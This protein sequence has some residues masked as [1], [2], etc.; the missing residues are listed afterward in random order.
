MLLP[1]LTTKAI[2][3]FLSAGP[4]ITSAITL[5]RWIQ[6]RRRS[7]KLR[8][9]LLRSKEL[10]E[11]IKSSPELLSVSG[12]ENTNLV[13][14]AKAHL[15]RTVSSANTL[16][17]RET[18]KS[19]LPKEVSWPARMFLFYAPRSWAAGFWHAVYYSLAVLLCWMFYGISYVED[20]DSYQWRELLKF[21]ENPSNVIV[22]TY[23]LIFMWMIWY[24][25][26]SKDRWDKALPL[27]KASK[28]LITSS[29]QNV[30]G[31]MARLLFVWSAADLLSGVVLVISGLRESFIREQPWLRNIHAPWPVRVV[32]NLAPVVTLAIAYLWARTE[33]KPEAQNVHVPFPRNVR[34]FYPATFNAEN[35]SRLAMF[36]IILSLAA[37]IWSSVLIYFAI[38]LVNNPDERSGMIVGAA[39]SIII[40]LL[41][42]VVLPCYGCYR[43]ALVAY[44]ARFHE[45]LTPS[46]GKATAV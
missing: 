2:T 37:L 3:T 33:S 25:A 41:F 27:A 32:N 6:E 11:F 22:L 46:A 8:D 34:F 39:M 40:G 16:F 12:T 14:N 43:C 17:M 23:Y 42:G 13:V 31:L 15:A 5:A 1:D 7:H 29:P 24:V 44:Y 38:P 36:W 35:W 28:L 10:L 4:V 18:I 21:L 20:N 9:H 45:Q 19:N 30:R 26:T